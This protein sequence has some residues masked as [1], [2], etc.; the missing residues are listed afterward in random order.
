[1]TDGIIRKPK[2]L[3]ACEF[4]GIVRETFKAKGWDAWS[5]DLLP[6]EIP[7]QHIQ[8][9]V[10]EL[11]DQNQHWDMM[12]CHPPCTYLSYAG[13]R[14]W[15]APGRAEK[16]TAT[17]EFFMAFVNAPI[18]RICVENPRGWPGQQYRKSDQEIHPYYFGGTE[19]KHRPAYEGYRHRRV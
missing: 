1:M 12:I 6:T 7:G 14:H 16:R 2:L 10:L 13:T 9:D 19:R 3:V 8:C 11:L 17:M 18:P 15:N 5:C 4:S